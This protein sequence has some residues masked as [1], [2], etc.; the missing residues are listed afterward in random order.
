VEPNL[1]VR[2]GRIRITA[3]GYPILIF[4]KISLAVK[5]GITQN[6]F[7][8]TNRSYGKETNKKLPNF[9]SRHEA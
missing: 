9:S 1:L 8:R 7:L 2:E 3:S 5:T 4:I 6:L